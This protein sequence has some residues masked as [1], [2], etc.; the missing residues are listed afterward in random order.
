MLIEKKKK[1]TRGVLETP[2]KWV[3]DT[4]VA[5]SQF[6]VAAANLEVVR[7]GGQKNAGQCLSFR[8]WPPTYHAAYTLY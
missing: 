3:Q 8:L 1:K 5:M 4:P 6:S 7:K 2:N